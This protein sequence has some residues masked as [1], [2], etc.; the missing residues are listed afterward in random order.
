MGHG[1][2]TQPPRKQLQQ[3][4]VPFHIW[5]V[6]DGGTWTEFYRFEHTYLLRFPELADFEVHADTLEVVCYPAPGG[7]EHSAEHLYLNQVLPLI[8][9]KKGELVFHASA[10]EIFGGAVAFAGEAGKGK[11]TLAASFALA[12][13][14][15]LTDDG[16]VLCGDENGF[17]V[18]PSHPSIRLWQDSEQALIH[19][20]ARRAPPLHF[21]SKTRF[22]ADED[23]VFCEHPSPLRRVYFLGENTEGAIQIKP[24]SA[25]DALV[26]WL[27]RS[28]LLDIEERPRL[29]SHFDQVSSL[30]NQQ[31]HYRLDYPRNYAELKRVQDAIINH[32]QSEN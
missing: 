10:V 4:S 24:A 17:K 11:S 8:L 1:Y 2:S 21:T 13:H 6:P 20:E 23:L 22:L 3:D 7:G 14:P 25:A 5:T 31:F 30:A 15:F 19:S 28:F 16:L 32:I 9:S 12:G 29:A 26:E 18:Q 27:R